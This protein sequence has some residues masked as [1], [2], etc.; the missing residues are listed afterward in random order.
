MNSPP[1]Q[2]LDAPDL[3]LDYGYD[4]TGA[5]TSLLLRE[6][7]GPLLMF[8]PADEVREW[9]TRTPA[10]AVEAERDLRGVS[11][12]QAILN[13][14]D[15]GELTADVAGP[16]LARAVQE[17]NVVSAIEAST[18]T[19]WLQRLEQELAG[20]PPA[21][22]S[23]YVEAVAKCP[24]LAL[25]DRSR[26]LGMLRRME[27]I[28]A[29]TASGGDVD[30]PRLAARRLVR[31]WEERRNVFGD[32]LCY[33]PMTLHGAMRDEVASVMAHRVHRILPEVDRGGRA[34]LLSDV[35][36]AVRETLS[37]KS[38]VRFAIRKCEAYG[39]TITM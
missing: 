1:S 12:H 26:R 15:R 38:E 36:K 24:E 39:M 8:T 10:E 25:N 37:I 34:V 11:A 17:L 2:C 29:A 9:S 3:D 16:A 30:C 6:D 35:S 20:I 22:K 23:A 33:L 18:E 28:T 31:H 32:D 14:Q 19:V 27:N 13:L 4:A 5:G 21:D 7:D